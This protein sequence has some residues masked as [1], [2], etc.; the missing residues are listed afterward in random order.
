MQR[1]LVLMAVVGAAV[2]GGVLL[3]A[4]RRGAG[5]SPRAEVGAADEV[6]QRLRASNPSLHIEKRLDDDFNRV[7]VYWVTNPGSSQSVP[8]PRSEVDADSV[9][10]AFV[11]CDSA[12]MPARLRFP[13]ATITACVRITSAEHVLDAFC[14]AVKA[15]LG[16]VIT[17]YDG[18]ANGRRFDHRYSEDT[19]HDGVLPDGSRGFLYSYFLLEHG[20]GFDFFVDA[21]VG[22]RRVRRA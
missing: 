3:F 8:V 2:A 6:L 11:P 9:V 1:L 14:Y 18:P 5:N 16:D 22:F 12:A 17:F 15:R 13:G 10:I 19:G 21:F 20:S 4:A 7:L